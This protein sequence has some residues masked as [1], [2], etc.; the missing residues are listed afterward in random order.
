[1]KHNLK[2]ATFIIPIRIESSDRLRNIITSLC[3]LVANFDTNIIVK[4][5]D[6]ESVFL[7]EALPQI[8]E[9]CGDVSSIKHI[10]EYS[11]DPA[12]HRQRVLNDMIMVTTTKVIVNY[13]CDIILP[14]NSYR[15]AYN[16]II[17]DVSDLVYPYGQG[18]FQKRIF[19]NNSLVSDFLNNEFDLKILETKAL[20]YYSMYGFCQF[21]NR[22]VYI[23]G[24]LENENFVAYAPEDVE[25]YFRFLTLGYRVHRINGLVY[26]LEHSRSENSWFNNP[27]ME[28]NNQEWERVQ[29]MNSEELSKY[30]QSQPYY[31]SRISKCKSDVSKENKC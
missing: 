15:A 1:M 22:A 25:R 6:K 21:F 2:D 11:N 23:E 7:K 13:D 9:F 12:F 3:F 5:V 24:G 16:L 28:E 20:N 8:E 14:I 27:F 18:E 31:L 29:K 19:A 10:F 30:I 17:E 26:H 4:E